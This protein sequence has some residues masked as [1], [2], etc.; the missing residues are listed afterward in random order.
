MKRSKLQ[1]ELFD[2]HEHSSYS[3]VKRVDLADQFFE[4]VQRVIVG[5]MRHRLRSTCIELDLGAFSRPI[6][7]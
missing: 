2:F 5:S 1:P 3:Y 4:I 6:L 7:L